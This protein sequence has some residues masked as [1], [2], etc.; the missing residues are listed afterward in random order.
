M[1]L[2]VALAEAGEAVRL[3]KPPPSPRAWLLPLQ[4]MW[5]YQ[6]NIK[7]KAGSKYRCNVQYLS[8]KGGGKTGEDVEM[9]VGRAR[10]RF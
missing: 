8:S 10:G 4:E 7:A 9:E 6:T 3:S 5:R 2:A 1:P